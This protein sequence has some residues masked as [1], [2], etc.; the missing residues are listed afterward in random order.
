M[1]TD[2]FYFNRRQDQCKSIGLMC[3]E[4]SNKVQLEMRGKAQCAARPARFAMRKI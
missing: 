2:L 1:A 4:K 3:T